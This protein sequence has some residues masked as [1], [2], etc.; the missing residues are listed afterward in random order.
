MAAQQPEWKELGNTEFL[1]GGA[2]PGETRAALILL[3]GRGGS[4]EDIFGLAPMLGMDDLLFLA[5]EAPGNTWYPFSFLSPI[6]QNEPSLS[7]ALETVARMVEVAAAAAGGASRVV[8]AGFSQGACLSLEYAARNPQSY[9]GVVALSGGLIGPP[10]TVWNQDGDFGG[11]PVF[12]GCSDVDPHIPVTRVRE[13][14]TH[15]RAMGANVTERIY[16]GM[17]HTINDDE[18]DAFRQ[19]L[20]SVGA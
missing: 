7:A 20:A 4:A 3:H 16:P 13:S 15:L 2:S 10:G 12:L 11:T 1:Q 17:G 9:G 14:T 6:A 18:L 5:P 8:L 19:I